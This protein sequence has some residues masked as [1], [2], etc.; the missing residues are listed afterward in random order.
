MRRADQEES[1]RFFATRFDVSCDGER[2]EIRIK[3][4]GRVVLLNH[5]DIPLSLLV[6]E[7]NMRGVA[8]VGDCRDFATALHHLQ[9]EEDTEH[10]GQVESISN[11]YLS[12]F[13]EGIVSTREA[14]I[15]A[16]HDDEFDA[17]PE[18][19][20]GQEVWNKILKEFRIAFPSQTHRCA[21]P[22]S[23]LLSRIRPS[24]ATGLKGRHL[25]INVKSWAR[26]HLRMGTSVIKEVKG[27]SGNR[28]AGF[29]V[30]LRF[31]TGIAKDISENELYVYIYKRS[32]RSTYS[33]C[34]ASVR[35]GHDLQWRLHKWMR[36][37]PW[38]S[39]D[40]KDKKT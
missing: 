6:Q 39:Q 23:D 21:N 22:V 5:P 17:G 9:V 32:S 13:L 30:I 28:K 12:N 34:R 2:H 19:G 4:N 24:V 29:Q 8:K 11:A 10:W 18:G 1:K 25:R 15:D 36:K 26:V 16:A 37:W 38:E 35:R 3:E 27:A 14:R 7:N 40:L 31:V 33:I 20:A